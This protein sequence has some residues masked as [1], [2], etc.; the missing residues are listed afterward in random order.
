[1][2]AERPA[3]ASV[4]AGTSEDETENRPRAS[5]EAEPL[6]LSRGN[7]FC[8][9][10]RSGDISPA[11]TPNLGLFHEDTRHLSLLEL[12]I[13]GQPA[14]VLSAETAYS[15][16]SQVDLT[17]TARDSDGFLDDPQNF[18]H[19]RRRQL[20]DDVFVERIIITNHL[21]RAIEIE[22]TLRLAADFADIFEVRGAH[23]RQ[24]GQALPVDLDPGRIVF[25]YRGAD[26]TTY[27]TIVRLLP[28]PDRL[29]PGYAEYGL[30]FQPGETRILELSVQ[31]VRGDAPESMWQ[32]FDLRVERARQAH[33]GF[34]A[35]T[36]RIRSSNNRFEAMVVRAL[37]DINSLRLNVGGLHV[38]GAGIPWFAAPF[39]RDSLITSLEMLMVAPQLAIET[40]RTLSAFQGQR[41]DPWREEEPG[42]IMHEL[43]RGELARLGEIPHSPYYGTI[44]ATPLWLVLLGETWRWTGDSALVEELAPTA[45]RA[46]A[47]IE[48]KLEAGGGFL[49]YRRAHERSLENQGW[50]DSRDAV[51]FPDGTLARAPI[52]LIE[53]QGYVVAA[54]E[55]MARLRRHLGDSHG[56]HRLRERAYELRHRIDRAFWVEE[57]GFF[58]LALDDENRQVPTI[59]S[60]PGHLGF[61][62]ALLPQRA[63][64]MAE[65]LMGDGMYSGWGIRTVARGQAVFNPLSYHNGSVWPHDNALCALGLATSGHVDEALRIFDGLYAASLHFR[66][67]RLPELFCGMARGEGDFLVHYPVS[68]SPQAWASASFFLLLQAALGIHPDAMLDRLTIRN[69]RLPAPIDHLSLEGIRVGRQAVSLRF[70]RHGSRTHV[71]LVDVT[72]DGQLT[73][74]IEMGERR[75]GPR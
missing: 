73:V 60:N 72:G 10:S 38:L 40:L 59:T 9:L 39:G 67:L 74:N 55:V 7:L 61:C 66:D 6:V 44:D 70:E 34:L 56:A 53:V 15:S 47:W 26:N 69:P 50:K 41:D 20:L 30:R 52:A 37:S 45:E 32:P 36:A 23:R 64:R 29:A 11:G 46:L 27:R 62:R 68:C 42:K 18:L 8:V 2:S 49:R 3:P 28:E 12:R 19:L 13:S 24:R 17:R 1:M 51:S 21:R 31:P 35:S 25:S 75:R 4:D 65:V 58:A 5:G 16:M 71:D 14:T 48:R 54:L 33:G 43:R 57:T 63:D 22:L